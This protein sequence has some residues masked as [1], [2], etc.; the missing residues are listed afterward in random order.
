MSGDC[1]AIL[2]SASTSGR[3][4]CET[5]VRYSQA[6]QYSS[7]DWEANLINASNGDGR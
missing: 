2:S 4:P 1:Q 6:E 5:P 7:T 3:D